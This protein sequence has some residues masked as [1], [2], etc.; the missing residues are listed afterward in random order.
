M[1]AINR[2]KPKVVN[3]LLESDSIDVN[4]LHKVHI[5]K[6]ILLG[7]TTVL[8]SQETRLTALFL[9]AKNGNVDICEKLLQHGAVDEIDVSSDIEDTETFI[10]AAIVYV[11]VD[12][13]SRCSNAIKPRSHHGMSSETQNSMSMVLHARASYAKT[14]CEMPACYCLYIE[15]ERKCESSC[16]GGKSRASGDPRPRAS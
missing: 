6:I 9:A 8:F 14:N 12:K 5:V 13:R 4:L 15:A 2:K 16:Q 1:I 10:M 3:A 11:T 7:L